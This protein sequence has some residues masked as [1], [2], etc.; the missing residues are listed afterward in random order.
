MSGPMTELDRAPSE[1][2]HLLKFCVHENHDHCTFRRAVE[3]CESD[4]CVYRSVA[5][6]VLIDPIVLPHAYYSQK[7]ARDLGSA[8]A[9]SSDLAKATAFHSKEEALAYARQQFPSIQVAVK[10]LVA[11]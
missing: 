7:I 9:W 6:F 3:R 11:R 4:G 1:W 8:H 2:S 5:R 10:E